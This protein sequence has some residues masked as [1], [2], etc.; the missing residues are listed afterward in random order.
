MK[1]MPEA[2][3]IAILTIPRICTGCD[4]WVP[5]PQNKFILSAASGTTSKSGTRE[6]LYVD[7]KITSHPK[8]KSLIYVFSVFLR[9]PYSS[10]VVYQLDIDKR[11]PLS[12]HAHD[13]PHEH[14]G[15][16]RKTNKELV[17]LSFKDALHHF[18][19]TANITFNPIP[20]D[21]TE[22]KLT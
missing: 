11:I 5:E 20:S 3:A 9:T 6:N 16:G 2:E 17:T 13:W 19:K 21:P 14:M 15:D 10:E 18:E 8:T 1:R 4:R 7:L 22:F 12:K